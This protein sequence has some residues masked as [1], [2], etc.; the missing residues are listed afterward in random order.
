MKEK[1]NRLVVADSGW[2][3]DIPEWILEEI[4]QERMINGLIG[5]ITGKEEIGDAELLAY[6]FTAC[7][8]S[9]ISHEYGEIYIYLTAK[10]MK[11]AKKLKDEDLPDF[12]REKLKQGLNDSEKYELGILKQELYRL[13]GGKIKSPLLDVLRDLKKRK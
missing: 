5:V 3:K 7:M 10:V 9:P 13:R 1:T 4:K 2:A 12:C 11:R 8:R 6:L